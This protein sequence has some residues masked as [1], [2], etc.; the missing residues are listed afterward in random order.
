MQEIA[1]KPTENC[2]SACA[3]FEPIR[4]AASSVGNVDSSWNGQLPGNLQQWP[5]RIS[6]KQFQFARSHTALQVFKACA[7]QFAIVS[8]DCEVTSAFSG[9]ALDELGEVLRLDP[10]H[11]RSAQATLLSQAGSSDSIQLLDPHGPGFGAT[12]SV[13]CI[14]DWDKSGA[15]HQSE[16]MFCPLFPETSHRNGR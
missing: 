2:G 14:Q 16:Q 12:G 8:S 7:A 9:Q 5:P 1:K 4:Q 15:L 10:F 6:V 13:T 11:P 3:L